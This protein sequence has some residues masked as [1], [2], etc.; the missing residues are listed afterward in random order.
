MSIDQIASEALRL[1]VW[2]RV[3][4]AT[5]LW[6][7]LD[8]PYELAVSLTAEEA[9]TLALERDAEVDCG[10]VAAIPHDEFMRRVRE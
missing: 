8:D 4:L 5:S 7:S 2:E 1:P 10:A 6:E 9:I 3:L